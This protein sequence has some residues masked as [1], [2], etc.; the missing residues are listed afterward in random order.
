MQAPGTSARVGEQHGETVPASPR[1]VTRSM[2]AVV[3]EPL[4][5]HLVQIA[6]K[7]ALRQMP[8]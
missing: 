6:K 8:R 2:S 5:H 3:A 1:A 4:Q 7:V